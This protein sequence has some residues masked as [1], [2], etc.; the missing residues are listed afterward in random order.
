MISLYESLRIRRLRQAGKVRNTFVRDFGIVEV[1]LFESRA[2]AT[3]GEPLRR[4]ACVQHKIQDREIRE[5]R[6]CCKPAG[7]V[8]VSWSAKALQFVAAR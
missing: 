2:A 4:P 8:L 7:E 3:I 5:R 1:K 6:R